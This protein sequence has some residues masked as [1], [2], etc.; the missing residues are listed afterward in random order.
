MEDLL[1][2]KKNIR[3]SGAGTSHQN[4]A[5]EGTIK[6]VVTMVSTIL[7][8][9]VLICPKET[10]STNFGQR[11]LTILYGYT[12]G[13]II[14]SMLYKILGKFFTYMF[15][16]Q[17]CRILEQ[18]FLN[19]LQGDKEGLKWVLKMITQHKLVWF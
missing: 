14:C 15:W 18:K 1:K 5:V 3:F 7:M 16:R 19:G 6:M 10:F 11:K 8:H 2:N 17:G 12:V 13:F 4:G 9:A